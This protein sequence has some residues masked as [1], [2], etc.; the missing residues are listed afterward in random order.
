MDYVD[1]I[2]WNSSVLNFM[3]VVHD[4]QIVTDRQAARQ[5]TDVEI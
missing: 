1:K 5:Q 2:K 3:T 4:P